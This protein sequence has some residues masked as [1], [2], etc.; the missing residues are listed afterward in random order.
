VSE[1][2]ATVS[3]WGLFRLT[4]SSFLAMSGK[5][6]AARMLKSAEWRTKGSQWMLK[7]AG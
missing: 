3:E 2:R 4:W 6:L 1:Q 5:P 7:P